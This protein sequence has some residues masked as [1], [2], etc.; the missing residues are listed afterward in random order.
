MNIRPS[1]LAFSLTNA[2]HDRFS[3]F[4][5]RRAVVKMPLNHNAGARD[6]K[7]SRLSGPTPQSPRYCSAARFCAG[8]RGSPDRAARDFPPL[9]PGDARDGQHVFRQRT[10]RGAI[11]RISENSP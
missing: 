4:A 7:T 11:L 1:R 9:H 10:V 6:G 2:A 3:P 8:W 5:K